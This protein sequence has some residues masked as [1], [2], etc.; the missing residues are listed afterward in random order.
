ML[1]R[2]VTRWAALAAAAILAIMVVVL[3]R[4]SKSLAEQ[5]LAGGPRAF[6][7]G[8]LEF[9]LTYNQGAAWGLFS[10]GQWFFVLVAVAVLVVI[11]AY[12]ALQRSHSVVMVISLGLFAGGSIGNAIDRFMTG[13]VVDFLRFMFIEF[14]IFN[15]ADTFITVGVGLL[16]LAMLLGGRKTPEEAS[17]V[18]TDGSGEAGDGTGAALTGDLD[19]P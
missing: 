19:Q 5:A 15:V 18:P 4:L 12:L 13:Q 11:I 7:P 2:Q 8:F 14:P 10:G 16:L 1:G 9:Q 6:I 17:L 3:D